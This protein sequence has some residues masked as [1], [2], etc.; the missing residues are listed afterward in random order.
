M[1]KVTISQANSRQ[2][3]GAS[4][5]GN[6]TSLPFKLVTG[7]SG[8]AVGADSSAP[9]KAGDIV[10]L[11]PLPSGMRLEDA[12]VFVSLG[13]TASVTGML[14]FEYEDGADSVLVPEDNA[15]F[16]NGINLATA[17][18]VRASG[19]SLVVLP[20]PARLILTIAGA[21]NAKASEI[22]VMVKGE[23]TGPQ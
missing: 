2:F 22:K 16:G 8:G 3:G 15:Y 14:G 12:D 23:L 7:A 9:L 21:D 17:G 13:M 10:D 20:K 18:R 11:G 6:L 19:S 4:P 5:Y 1:A